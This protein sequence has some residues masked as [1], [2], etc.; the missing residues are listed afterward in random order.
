[1]NMAIPKNQNGPDGKLFEGLIKK[2]D[3]QPAFI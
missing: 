2:T 3:R 1:M